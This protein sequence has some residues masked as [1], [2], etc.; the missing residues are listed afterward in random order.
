MFQ[1]DLNSERGCYPLDAAI[2]IFI[3]FVYSGELHY[4]K[5]DPLVW[6][7][8][9]NYAQ[10]LRMTCHHQCLRSVVNCLCGSMKGGAFSI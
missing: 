7:V 9:V 6:N 3:C 1:Y 5:V 8:W 4:Q 2:G 10:V